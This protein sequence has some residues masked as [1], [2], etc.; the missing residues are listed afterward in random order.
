MYVHL[1][2]IISII[3]KQGGDKGFQ[4]DLVKERRMIKIV[5]GSENNNNKH[6]YKKN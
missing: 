6:Y 2:A 4:K 1:Y 3:E 5:I